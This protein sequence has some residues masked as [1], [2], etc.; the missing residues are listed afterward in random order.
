MILFRI[1]KRL[2][3]FALVYDARIL[4]MT[5]RGRDGIPGLERITGETCNITEW[6]D[7]TFYDRVWYEDN[8]NEGFKPGRWLGVSHRVGSALC[9][10]VLAQNG[11][12][13][14]RTTVQHIPDEDLALE[15]V[16]KT[17]DEYDEVVKQRLDD[18]NFVLPNGEDL[19]HWD[20]DE[21][22]DDVTDDNKLGTPAHKSADDIQPTVER[23]LYDDEQYDALLNAEVL[24]P[25]PTDKGS[26]IRGSVLKRAKL[27]DGT[28]KGTYNTNK[29]LD[30]RR[31]IIR[32]R[33]GLEAELRH[34]EIAE[35]LFAGADS[36][37]RQYMQLDQ[38][39]DHRSDDT[40]IKKDNGW[41]RH[42]TNLHR[43]K[44]TKGWEFL[45][46]WKDKS[47]DWIPLKD[48]KECNPIEV[49]EY[50]KA[51]NLIDEP[52]FSWWCHHVLKTRTA[53]IEKVKSRYHKM[54]HKFGLKVPK[55][56][57]EAHQIDV[58]NG[59][60]LWTD[61]IDK[62]MKTVKIAYKPYVHPK[63]GLVSPQQVRRDRQKY[64]I[65]YT[66]I[67]CHMIFDVKLDGSFTRK[68]RFVADGSRVDLPKSLTYYESHSS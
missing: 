62:E 3:C 35:N 43:K 59:N 20:V 21:S 51:N 34:N 33:N 56:V 36:Q 14:S 38:I 29:A 49:T 18:K 64:L 6:L 28:P 11:F 24:L 61:S 15:S 17:L 13:L 37:G 41:I 68:A 26:Y 58:E 40:A 65:R 25:D 44:T 63:E 9:Y 50:V 16:K 10:F 23:D 32:L 54:T 47:Q 42:R 55:T 5:A 2:W 1:P 53:I 31:Y 66:E 27:S 46:L 60:T 39:V 12:V 67:K 19:F 8:P 45:C 7:F 57:D 52:A 30:S 4:S 48:L 22:E